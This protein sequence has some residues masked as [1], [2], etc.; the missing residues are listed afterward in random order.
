QAFQGLIRQLLV[1]RDEEL[2]SWRVAIREALGANG[3][4]VVDLVPELE[5]LIGPQLPVPEMPP[6]EA[7]RRFLASF[8]G[9]LGVFARREHLLVLF[10][11]DLQW[12]DAA[13]LQFLVSIMTRL[14]NGPLLA[15]GAY[16]DN[17]VG[18][19]HPLRRLVESVR[20]AS[21]R[22]EE[23]E[24]GPLS[25]D[26]CCRLVA[27]SVGYGASQ[28]EAVGQL[29]HEKTA[30]NPFFAIQFLT[31]LWEGRLLAFDTTHGA[32]TW[33]LDA[34]R[35]RGFSDNVADLMVAKLQRLPAATQEAL[36]RF[37][38]VGHSAQVATLAMVQGGSA[39][40]VH[41]DLWEALREGLV[42]RRGDAYG[43]LHDRVQEA[44]YALTPEGRRP[45]AHVRIGR[46][47]LAHLPQEAVSDRVFEIVNQLNRGVGL[48]TDLSERDTLRQL[49][50]QAGR[51]AQ[52]ATAYAAARGYLRQATALLRLDAWR[53]QY[54]DTFKVHLELCE[55]EYLISHFDVAQDLSRLL[56]EH[57]RSDLDRAQ[58]YRLRIRLGQL[59]GRP[60]DALTALREALQ[61][62][63]MT[64]PESAADI[65]AASEAEHR[66]VAINLGGRRVAE[67]VDAPAATD[68]TVQMIIGLIAESLFLAS[69]WTAQ[70]SYFPWLAT[71]GVN[72]CLRHGHSAESSSLDEGYA[73][74]RV[75]VGD[76]PSAFEFSD[77]ALRLAAKFDNPRLQ[78]IVR[79]RHGFFINPWCSHIATSLPAL[80]QSFA[81][82]VQAGDVLYAGYAGVHAVELSLEKGDRL[83]DVLAMSRTY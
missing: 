1:K 24:L 78:A 29:L 40:A 61:L 9:F 16:R 22:V 74:A 21:A 73:R 33:D 15:I 58:V 82:L 64:W 10:L 45:E 27:E 32:W 4:L 47:L 36:Q 79:F 7:E 66:A 23:I 59:A 72:I 76:L 37:A 34:I 3:R 30:G 70:H 18:P 49:N 41:A 14:N 51:R 62:F 83:D 53:T 65:Q 35:A 54:E 6:R 71:R 67:L 81:A 5:L 25:R 31:A 43:F 20:Q 39:E 48:I 17:E 55:C 46:R 8:G 13:T 77:L 2:A 52:H 80:H 28:V 26:D 19:A 69:G 68:P 75:T 11:D 50:A 56:L 42:S 57:A 12:L 63:G 60:A 38:C 44:A